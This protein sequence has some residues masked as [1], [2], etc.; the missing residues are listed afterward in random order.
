MEC[1]WLHS[2]GNRKA[3][4]IRVLASDGLEDLSVLVLPMCH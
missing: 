1:V 2:S 4:K 3:K